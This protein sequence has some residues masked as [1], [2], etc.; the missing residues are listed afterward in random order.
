MH[1]VKVAGG[2]AVPGNPSGIAELIK[3]PADLAFAQAKL[4][5]QRLVLGPAVAVLTGVQLEAAIE[6]LRRV[7]QV[8]ITVHRL[9]DED[10]L[11]PER[12]AF[13]GLGCGNAW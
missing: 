6:Q 3:R 1:R 9:R 7:A 8:G 4:A 13:A 5:G 10:E 12:G 11:R 2:P